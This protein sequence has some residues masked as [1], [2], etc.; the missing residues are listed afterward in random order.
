MNPAKSS[1]Q[2]IDL[3]DLERKLRNFVEPVSPKTSSE[4]NQ[5]EA[6]KPR[7]GPF[8][9]ANATKP[10][11]VSG[12]QGIEAGTRLR[13]GSGVTTPKHPDLDSVERQLREVAAT[14]LHK[15]TPVLKP[16]PGS[17]AADEAPPNLAQIAGR[18]KRAD[19]PGRERPE[20]A[21]IA[22]VTPIDRK[23]SRGKPPA[24]IS[25][26]YQG[27]LAQ[28]S[29]KR[30]SE[31]AEAGNLPSQAGP[32]N[33]IKQQ[34]TRAGSQAQVVRRFDHD[35][36]TFLAGA[37][38]RLDGMERVSAEPQAP[39]Y[40]PIA[41]QSVVLRS[42]RS[43]ALPLLL[44]ALGTGTALVM[45]SPVGEHPR[46]QMKET[47][48]QAP[49]APP[50]R[51]GGKSSVSS[52][53]DL[54][55]SP[56]QKSLGSAKSEPL[57]DTVKTAPPAPSS[58]VPLAMA[59]STPAPI[60]GSASAPPSATAKPSTPE[61]A[62]T[63]HDAKAG[64]GDLPVAVPRTLDTPSLPASLPMAPVT[65]PPA[66]IA[67]DDGSRAPEAASP[68]AAFT[69]SP[70]PAGAAPLVKAEDAAGAA[71]PPAAFAGAEQA[72]AEAPAESARPAPPPEPPIASSSQLPDADRVPSAS[73]PAPYRS[74]SSSPAVPA[75][76]ADGSAIANI[77]PPAAA[78]ESAAHRPAP[79][80]SG[81]EMAAEPK[82]DAWR[83]V[84][85]PAP[86]APGAVEI[87][88]TTGG[89]SG[90]GVDS[91]AARASA[92][93]PASG[94][95]VSAPAPSSSKSGGGVIAGKPILTRPAKPAALIATSHL[96]PARA[97]RP[98]LPASEVKPGDDQAHGPSTIG[99]PLTITPSED[100]DPV[101]EAN[102]D[103]APEPQAHTPPTASRPATAGGGPSFS[104][105]LASSLSESDARATLSQL[106]REFPGAL[107]TGSVTRDNLGS[108]G[109]FYRVKAGP[110]SREA[111][112][113]V[114]S[115]LRAAGRKCVLTRG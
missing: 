50:Q 96:P 37:G 25:E 35:A 95:P 57:P 34:D 4:G 114:C 43:L 108:Y 67:S 9:A 93:S 61:I 62:A 45:L 12:G 18:D 84:K 39:A 55:V 36:R 8:R 21:Q 13:S 98:P 69:S 106:Q 38:S 97:A 94:G 46:G 10:S 47:Q 44:L 48:L 104:L 99:A 79:A 77:S 66:A 17:K 29:M 101:L 42:A 15:P 32:A 56:E 107:E 23:S 7:V 31:Q 88:K 90:D 72:R 113:R 103:P 82:G 28:A 53:L 63:E 40:A 80:G 102:A 74:F 115:R 2:S 75:P 52:A 51:G 76:A 59:P 20:G 1:F 22:S 24:E 89:T 83:S 81:D 26:V 109:V 30:A 110:L 6:T 14:V 111:A 54:S 19:K 92:P 71:P 27:R 86:D 91:A 16:A 105:R 64:S 5:A 73:S 3:D 11:A 87:G 78:P 100:S 33:G 41:T 112:E 49:V 65:P 70:G 58:P 68:S 60:A 85:V